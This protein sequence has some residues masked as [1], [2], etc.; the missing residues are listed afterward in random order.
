MA[1][2]NEKKGNKVPGA[3]IA[4][5]AVII[6]V[7]V[8]VPTVYMPYKNKKPEYDKVHQEALDT[9]AYW[10]QS[11]ENRPAIDK[12]IDELEKEWDKFQKEMFVDAGS[13][14]KDLQ[15]EFDERKFH[16]TSFDIGP[17]Q[18]DGS[19]KV[20]FT[21]APLYNVVINIHAYS[22]EDTL[23]SALKYL[24]E[25]SIGCYYVKSLNANTFGEEKTVDSEYT[26]K[27]GDLDISMEVYLYY[28]NQKVTPV[29]P[30]E[31]PEEAAQS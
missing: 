13:T 12:D 14:L 20:S 30:E 29:L 3:A 15:K 9:L 31:N 5:I 18:E 10:E 7:T 21:G 23:L 1:K 26:A 28:F 6:A 16:Y 8:F 4:I 24:E 19:G 25:E 2:T 17:E 11:I 27:V 22:D